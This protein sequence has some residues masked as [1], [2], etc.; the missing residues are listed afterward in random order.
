[1]KI[2]SLII[3]CVALAMAACGGKS[4]KSAERDTADA[5]TEVAAVVDVDMLL[6]D[7]E[8]LVG[9]QVAVDGICTHI[10]THGGRKMF[11]M[12]SD[13]SKTIRI[14]AAELGSF[15]QKCMNSIVKVTGTLREERID[16]AYLKRW[17]EQVASNTAEEHGDEGEGGCSTEKAARGE[18]GNTVEQRI[19]DFRTKIA[20]RKA[21]EGK[22]YLSF[23]YVEAQHYEIVE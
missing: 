5:A 21:A 18:T 2:K 6:S 3:L 23:Y 1:M 12:G 11:L 9:R 10:C 22:E 20:A 16:E 17:E 19:A 15:D 14:E 13:D 7:G 8:E 4:T